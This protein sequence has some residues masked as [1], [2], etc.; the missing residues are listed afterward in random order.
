MADTKNVPTSG[1]SGE[2]NLS[3]A[4]RRARL[5]G[6]L[7]KVR[8]QQR[9]AE[10]VDTGSDDLLD[11]SSSSDPP[12]SEVAPAVNYEPQAHEVP[13]MFDL[14]MQAPQGQEQQMPLSQIKELLA[15]ESQAQEFQALESQNQDMTATNQ[16]FEPSLEQSSSSPTQEFEAQEAN[17]NQSFSQT[18]HLEEQT[19]PPPV[20]AVPVETATAFA[21]GLPTSSNSSI[22]PAQLMQVLEAVQS[23]GSDYNKHEAELLKLAQVIT[24]AAESLNE[25][26]GQCVSAVESCI[27]VAGSAASS[28][29]SA[30]SAAD[31]FAG[32]AKSIE[33]AAK[34]S[35]KTAESM[36]RV[37]QSVGQV[38]EAVSDVSK[39]VVDI[40]KS[41][42]EILSNV[43][44]GLNACATNLAA[45]Q[46][47]AQEQSELLRN[48]GENLHNN[49]FAE[50]SLNLNGLTEAL[51]AAIEPMNATGTLLQAIDHLVATIESK[52]ASREGPMAPNQ[53]VAN[54]A[55]QLCAGD[56]DPW[57]F[58]CAYTAVFPD[59]HPADL[60]RRLVE[61]L[62]TQRLS[63]DLFRAAYEAVQAAEP[64][65][66]FAMPSSIPA[67]LGEDGDRSAHDAEILN[68]LEQLHRSNREL[69][70][71]Q[72]QRE[73]ELSKLLSQKEQELQEAQGLL[74]S[75][76]EEF[77]TR[78]E[79]VTAA[80]EKREAEYKDLLDNKEQEISEKDSELSLLR[81]QM[82]EL[83]SQ[84]QEMVKEMQSQLT[85]MK[86]EAPPAKE[87]GGK[88]AK[89]PSQDFFEA[90]PSGFR[91]A[92]AP[93][94]DHSPVQQQ[95][96][97]ES[98]QVVAPAD[99]NPQQVS[100]QQPALQQ[101]QAMQPPQ[102]EP[103]YQPPVQESPAMP[104]PPK[105]QG[106][107]GSYGSGVRAQV[108][109]VIVRQA[110]AGA[111]WK[112]ICAGPM[113]ANRISPD[114]VE[115]EVQR[116]QALLNR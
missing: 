91:T 95:P 8:G 34:S 85:A 96:E 92:P 17:L 64:P 49:T 44:Q 58:K 106:A 56:I 43:D 110:L 65:A 30:A 42:S 20:P 101:Q 76:Y 24:S 70:Q 10:S 1:S 97:L 90:A 18:A 40:A 48:F 26:S 75:R 37:S 31:T 78:Y 80:L 99:I 69:K 88:K 86:T 6:S 73:G 68:Q 61:L 113:Q 2:D 62:G 108:F 103:V 63:G 25:A 89:Q 13:P 53:L 16:V 3:P 36:N 112:E 83:R 105:Q 51:S 9:P 79:E 116:R 55:D 14:E 100:Q 46:K 27:S 41:T 82:E 28:A 66:R 50:I 59:D 72:E 94:F 60:L 107:A 23:M 33:H 4:A 104:Q 7:A 87:Q 21:Q 22:D 84:T 111:P 35:G 11:L 67:V 5:R 81:N 54:L 115:A 57:T 15:Q 29:S 74:S 47:T 38:S 71:A 109:E 98:P 12:E 45:L 114:E 93:V 39:S 19:V 52:E 32:S 77:N 102:P